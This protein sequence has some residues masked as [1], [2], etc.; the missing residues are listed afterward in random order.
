MVFPWF[1][2]RFSQF[3]V[4]FPPKKL[5]SSRPEADGGGGCVTCHKVRSLENLAIWRRGNWGSMG[6][7]DIPYIYGDLYIY[8]WVI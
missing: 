8:I 1:F 3:H 2:H 7:Y 6:I 5:T 4:L